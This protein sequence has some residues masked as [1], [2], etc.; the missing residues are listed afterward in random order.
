[1]SRSS[2]LLRA[3]ASASSQR[4]R[5]G[6][7][8]RLRTHFSSCRTRRRRRRAARPQGAA[9]ARRQQRAPS[10]DDPLHGHHGRAPKKEG[11]HQGLPHRE[12]P[13]RD[14]ERCGRPSFLP[15]S[16]TARE[17]GR[18]GLASLSTKHSTS[19]SVLMQSIASAGDGGEDASR[20]R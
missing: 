3:P 18:T 10:G 1:V 11:R 16:S 19:V 15:C 6:P 12:L 14:R 17:R 2:W 5:R 7:L 8:F 4:R 9:A 20:L 13:A